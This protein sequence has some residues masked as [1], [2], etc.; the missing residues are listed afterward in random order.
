MHRENYPWMALALIIAT[1]WSSSA[2][3]N[4]TTNY[5]LKIGSNITTE[6]HELTSTR[7]QQMVRVAN[8]GKIVIYSILFVIA[9]VGN[10]TAFIALLFMNRLNRSQNF[11]RIRMLFMNLCIADLMVTYIH[12]PLEIIWAYTDAWLAGEIMCKLMMFLRTFGL[13]LSSFIIIT[14]TIDRFYV[15]VK[16]L[17]LERVYRLN[18]ILIVMSWVVSFLS[19]IPQVDVCESRFIVDNYKPIQIGLCF[20]NT[21][22]P[23]WSHIPTM[24]DV[25]QIKHG[26]EKDRLQFVSFRG[27]LRSP[28]ADH[29]LLLCENILHHNHTQ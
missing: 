17:E 8:W 21:Q 18:K 10:T 25:R 14:I 23:A 4:E 9:S 20:R 28:A 6:N 19:S 15:I 24:R 22:S 13:Y 16:P 27:L 29:D 7:Q 5:S 12:L 3:L 26:H 2:L 1:S 11:T